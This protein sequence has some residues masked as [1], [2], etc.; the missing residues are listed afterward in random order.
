MSKRKSP[1]ILPNAYGAIDSHA[2]IEKA[3]FGDEQSAVLARAW[4]NGLSGIIAIATGESPGIFREVADLAHSDPRIWGAVGIHPHYASKAAEL[5][6]HVMEVLGDERIVAIGEI[7]LD[8]HYEFSPRDAQREALKWQLEQALRR[9]VPIVLHIRDAHDEALE[10]LD[11]VSASWTGVVH[12]FTGPPSLAEEFLKRGFYISIPGVVTFGTKATDLE[13][14]VR[15]IPLERMLVETDSPYLAPAP[16][17]GRRNEP[18]NVALVV[19]KIAEIRSVDSAE[20][21]AATARNTISLFA[22]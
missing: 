16:F 15:T 12:C 8:F 20:I 21:A 10:M 6:P 14:T 18:A 7:G 11:A 5:K 3:V 2:H 13:R 1:R 22:L 17:R 4:E 19:E 9:R